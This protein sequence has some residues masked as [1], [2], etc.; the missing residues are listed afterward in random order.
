MKRWFTRLAGLLLLSAALPLA[1]QNPQKA[2]PSA[3]QS[4]TGSLDVSSYEKRVT[5]KTLPNGLTVI[6]WRRPE[7]P[8][9]SF[10]TMVDAGSAQDPLNETGL[11]HMMEHMAFKGTPDIGTTDYAAEKPALEKVEQTYAAY[12]AERIKRVGQDPQKLA[13]LKQAWQDAIKAADQYVIKNQFA[14]VIEAHGG[15]GVNAFTNYDETAY[16]YSLPS[17][18]IELWAALESDRMKHPVMREFYK[19]R[20]VVMEERRMR[21]DSKPTGRLV[22]Q[23]L[24]T[25]F[26]ANPYHRPTIGYAL[27]SAELLR[28]RRR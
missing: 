8:V 3:A 22:E 16:M 4:Q 24:G 12:N 18:Q 5:V 6:L 19:E 9:F 23:F 10:F 7:A 28:H 27:R 13:Q 21:T 1:A 17:N 2:S 20:S 11:A 26:M 14:E 25:A 15:V